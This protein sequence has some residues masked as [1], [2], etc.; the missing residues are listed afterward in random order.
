[1]IAKGFI[2]GATAY[3]KE[4][5]N[6]LDFVIVTSSII[7]LLAAAMPRPTDGLGFLASLKV[8][9]VLRPLRLV[10]RNKGMKLIVRSLFEALP[11]VSNVFGVVLT[12]QIVFAIL[13]LQ[14]FMGDLRTCTDPTF[15][16]RTECNAAA[17]AAASAAAVA[18]GAGWRNDAV[19]AWTNPADVPGSFDDFGSVMLLLYVMSTADDWDVIMYHTMDASADGHAPV[20]NDYSPASLFSI[21]WMFVGSFFAMNLFVGVIVD[22]FNRIKKKLEQADEGGTATMTSDQESWAK[23]L[24]SSLQSQELKKR[25][26][27][28]I[29]PE[30]PIR[31]AVYDFITSAPFEGAI[32]IVIVANILLMATDHYGIEEDEAFYA[33]YQSATET[34][35]HIYYVECIL[36]VIGMGKH[37]FTDRWCQLDFFLVCIALF[38]EFETGVISM[39][40]ASEGSTEL[41]RV[42]RVLRILRILRLLKG[43][44]QLKKLVLTILLCIA[45][46]INI[47]AL[48]VLIVYIYSILGV[49]VSLQSKV[50]A[51]LELS[52]TQHHSTPTT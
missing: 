39:V 35:V 26:R 47:T 10:S 24:I 7:A 18:D 48:L 37:Y 43:A 22:N 34:V 9:R 8:L 38:D 1:M 4:G 46:L 30:H 40:G 6:V 14:L 16:T 15:K 50:S 27:A 3:L 12:F 41:L 49:Q 23:T 5:W 17:A 25:H 20:R 28:S 52:S 2:G 42:L 33:F 32:F 31:R 44:K 21:L 45:P 36:K 29:A 19:V 51:D 13:G 11:D